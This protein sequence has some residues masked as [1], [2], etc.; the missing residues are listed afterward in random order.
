MCGRYLL[1]A[2]PELIARAVGLEFSQT[3]RDLGA[4]ELRPRFNIAPSQQV[5]IVR[6]RSAEEPKL[7]IIRPR[8]RQS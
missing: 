2:D 6:N 4:G 1:R 3:G 7:T 8:R 5:P